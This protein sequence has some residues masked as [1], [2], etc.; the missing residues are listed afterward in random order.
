MPSHGP[1]AYLADAFTAMNGVMG[2]L[3]LYT[4]WHRWYI[5]TGACLLLAMLFDGLDGRMARKFGTT[6]NYGH[7]SDTVSDIVSWGVAISFLVYIAIIDLD[8]GYALIAILPAG[9]YLIS[10]F[11]RLI[12]YARRGYKLKRFSGLPSPGG[13]LMTLVLVF[14][15][16]P[17]PYLFGSAL[18]LTILVTILSP[19]MVSPVE[20]PK[21]RGR[22]LIPAIVISVIVGVPGIYEYL[23]TGTYY[24]IET[25]AAAT[26]AFALML[27]YVLSGP[28][29]AVRDRFRGATSE[30]GPAPRR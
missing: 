6:H 13:A 14:L 21:V 2:V 10:A 8:P 25:Q 27:G 28:A 5:L 23:T 24:T 30:D 11:S 18:V 19:L 1:T 4:T 3:S 26:L 7:I 16:G 15:F 17:T 29:L 20:Y 9:V 22:W 12:N